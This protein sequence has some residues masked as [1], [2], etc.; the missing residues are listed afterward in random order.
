MRSRLMDLARATLRMTT[1][2]DAAAHRIPCLSAQPLKKTLS[3]LAP[4][5]SREVDGEASAADGY[6]R[7]PVGHGPAGNERYLH[8]ASKLT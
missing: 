7:D 6:E 5:R 3:M 1:S 2:S 4:T 8:V